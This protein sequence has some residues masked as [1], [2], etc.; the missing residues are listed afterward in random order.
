MPKCNKLFTRKDILGI[1]MLML[2]LELLFDV[3]RVATVQRSFLHDGWLSLTGQIE[4]V[5]PKCR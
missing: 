1:V 5:Q 3:L 2:F 4:R